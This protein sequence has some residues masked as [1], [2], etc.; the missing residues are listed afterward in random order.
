VEK[1][2]IIIVLPDIRSL[3]NVGS[4]FRTADATG[5]EK[6]YCCGTTGTPK[7]HKLRKVALGA[8]LTVPWEYCADTLAVLVELR[9]AGYQIVVV[10]KT[11]T[12]QLYSAVQYG[13]K[14]TLVFGAETSGVPNELIAQA[15]VVAHLPMFGR[16]NSI[17]VSVA[18]GVMLYHLRSLHSA[19]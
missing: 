6:I 5:V 11:T 7:N 17:N 4:F 9:Q 3:Y 16:K 13:V 15:D 14:V 18:G 2:A 10:E 12:S 1:L 8:E 19:G